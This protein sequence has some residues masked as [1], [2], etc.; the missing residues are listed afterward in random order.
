[1]LNKLLFTFCPNSRQLFTFLST[2]VFSSL[3]C[4]QFLEL[5]HYTKV[6]LELENKWFHINNILFVTGYGATIQIYGKLSTIA[7]ND[8]EAVLCLAKEWHRFPS[9]FF[10]PNKFRVEFIQS[11]FRGQLP[12]HFES[13]VKYPTRITP[14][15]M[16]DQNREETSRYVSLSQCDFIIDSDYSEHYGRDLAYSKDLSNWSLL[17]KF[18]F[19]DSS[20]SSSLWRAFYVPFLSDKY[21]TYIDY[22]L[23][24]NKNGTF[25]T[26]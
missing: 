9:N 18:P 3:F 21:C 14:S 17:Y 25:L 26:G 10:I 12:K 7:T 5:F 23:L 15:H 1:M 11:E 2:L 16:N 20:R 4:F 19:L 13:S 24:S 6:T 8:K 22:N